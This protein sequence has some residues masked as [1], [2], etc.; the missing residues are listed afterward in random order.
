[1]VKITAPIHSPK[2]C[3]ALIAAGA[4]ELYCGVM[5]SDSERL[6]FRPVRHANLSDF[7]SLK[8]LTGTASA[9]NVPVYFCLNAFQAGAG[10]AL[11]L[12]QAARA[13]DCG[14]AGLIIADFSLIPTLRKLAPGAKIILGT[15]ASC[16]NPEAAAFYAG[17]GADRVVL[18]RQ[19][20]VTEIREIAAAAA[21]RGL[22]TEI[23]VRNITCLNLNG[24][25]QLH[26]LLETLH[27]GGRRLPPCRQAHEISAF[28]RSAAPVAADAGLYCGACAAAPLLDSGLTAVKIVG[29]DFPA[30][31]ILA[32]IK[33]VKACL[34]AAE[35]RRGGSHAAAGA[36]LHSDIYGAACRAEQCFYPEIRR[37]LSG[38]GAARKAAKENSH[39]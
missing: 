35:T 28:G 18:E 23:F 21:E 22:E 24:L 2:D 9:K 1:M 11:Q 36:A 16:S 29:R 13:L 33:F 25:C 30:P 15:A 26:H 5:A 37:E 27:S 34:A 39:G 6:N 3:E 17:A 20:T 12:D 8:K 7:D 19:L 31:R 38:A 32:D 10:L 14:A 4:D